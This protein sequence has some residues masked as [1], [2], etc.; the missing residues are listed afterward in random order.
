M[1]NTAERRREFGDY[2]ARLRRHS[3]RS[4]P[5]LA[6]ALCVASGTQSITRNEVSRWERGAR[7][8]DTWLPF[9]ATLPGVAATLA[10]LL[11][12]VDALEPLAAPCGR[13]IGA[14]TVGA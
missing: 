11:P 13:R 6:A 7:V 4:Q 12:D 1:S 3:G 10:D 5:Q 8:P 9:L 14:T 2:L